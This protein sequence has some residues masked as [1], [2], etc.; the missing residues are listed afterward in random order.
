[1]L[2][3]ERPAR[4]ALAFLAVL[5]IMLFSFGPAATV[6]RAAGEVTL[7]A[8]VLLQGHARLGSW[9]AIEVQ[10]A[11]DGPPL[12]GELRLVGGSS[13]RTRFGT[14]VD[15]PTQSRKTYLL[16]AQPPAFIT[17]V[18]V[19]LVAGDRTVAKRTVAFSVHDPTQLVVGVV[20]ERPQRIVESIRLLPN[21]SGLSAPAIVTLAPADLPEKV[22]SWSTLDR[23]IWQDIDTSLLSPQQLDAL[24]GWLA[25]GGRLVVAGGTAGPSVLGGLP[26]EIL[27]FRPAA[28]IDLPASALKGLLGQLPP[29]AGDLVALSGELARGRALAATGDRVVAAEAPYG[30][31]NVTILGFD[32]TTDWISRTSAADAL[33]RRLVPSRT[34]GAAIVGDDSQLVNA[35]VNLPSLAVPPVGGLLLLLFGYIV[36]IGPINYLVLRRLDR[37]EWAWVTMPVLV[38]VFSVAS[39]GIGSALRG[40]DL[41][42]NEV[43][44]VRGAPGTSE[45]LAQVYL[46]IFSPSRASYQV[47]IPGGALLSPPI[48]GGFF[49]NPTDD[50]SALDVLQG[51]PARIRDLAVGFGSLRAIRAETASPVPKV[52][53]NLR[54]EG[55]HLKGTFRNTSSQTLERPAVVL[56]GNAVL[57]GDLAPGA[58]Q[59]VDLGITGNAFGQPLSDKVV[60]QVFF[61][62][63]GTGSES[64]A[65]LAARH[66]IVDQLSFDP[67][68]GISGQLPTESPVIL[69][70]GSKSVLDVRI[71]G[72]SANRTGTVLYYIPVPMRVTGHTIFRPDLIRSSVVETDALFFNKDPFSLNFG[73]GKLTLAYRPIAF[74]GSI[75]PQKLILAMGFD[76]S[77]LLPDDPPGDP[78]EGQPVPDRAGDIAGSGGPNGFFDGLPEVELF[79]ITGDRWV[80][81]PHLG[82][83]QAVS[84]KDPARFVDGASGTVLTRFVNDRQDGV[85]FQFSLQIEGEI[86]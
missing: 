35:L 62:G 80:R 44:I 53:A 49:G 74:E 76:P 73:K 18:E 50:P 78:I 22:E 24:R 61:G 42:V 56:G 10:V 82:N 3:A 20:A 32:P 48:N 19:Q 51:D 54:L 29:G 59:A 11:N 58:E 77:R 85:G 71:E 38:V 66:G 17:S 34:S 86:R 79:D 30:N 75:D 16:Y 46:G 23:L 6:T 39:F 33:W 25:S 28:T 2:T 36:L 65:R 31:G 57:F 64:M 13:G 72:H 69:A 83:G 7:D 27:P 5:A 84:V 4:P 67:N 41:I 81:L 12:Q 52:E 37:R 60:G 70:W 26:D 1:M 14:V 9:M 40:T 45:G 43:A 55:D 63:P 15:L 8:R 68:F 47:S 21:Q